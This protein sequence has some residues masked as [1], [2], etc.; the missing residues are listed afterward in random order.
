[1]IV[2]EREQIRFPA[3]DPP[4][5]QRIPGPQ[6]VRIARLEPAEHRIAGGAAVRAR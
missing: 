5:V 2:D 3:A 1:M 6:L 4:A